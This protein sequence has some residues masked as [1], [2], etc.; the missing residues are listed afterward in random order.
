MHP[1]VHCRSRYKSAG[2]RQNKNVGV[3]NILML[4]FIFIYI[5]CFAIIKDKV[6]NAKMTDRLEKILKQLSVAIEEMIFYD[7]ED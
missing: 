1:Q 4:S 3:S 7:N 5:L 2:F 6:K